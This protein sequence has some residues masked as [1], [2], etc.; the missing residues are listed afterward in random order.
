MQHATKAYGHV[1]NETASARELEANLLLR[2]AARFQAISDSWDN[3]K[4]ELSGALLFNRKLWTFF[5]G[6]ISREDNPLPLDIRRNVANLGV[7]VLKQ[8]MKMTADPKP[9]PLGT[10]ININRQLA[11][12][13]NSKA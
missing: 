9:E 7:F 4:A 3:R 2:S 6:S 11:S 1:L 10:L 5:L 13:L 8:T 12:G